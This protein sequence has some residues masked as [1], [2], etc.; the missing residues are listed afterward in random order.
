LE[1]TKERIYD[2][3]VEIQAKNGLQPS[4][5][6]DLNRPY[7]FTIEMETERAKLMFI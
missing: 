4:A 3:L 6:E 7:N 1:L 2:N 5:Y